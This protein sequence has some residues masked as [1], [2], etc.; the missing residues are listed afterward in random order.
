M[1]FL[2]ILVAMTET[3]SSRGLQLTND[4]PVMRDPETSA[5]APRWPFAV[6]LEGVCASYAH[7]PHPALDGVRLRLDPG[8]RV[9]LVGPSGAGKTTVVNLLLRFLDP[10]AGRVTVA[11]RDAREYRQQDVRRTIAVAG[12]EAHLFTASIR[13]NVRLARPDASDPD[14][15]GA[16]ARADLGLGGRASQRGRHRGRGAGALAVRRPAPADC[17]GLGVPHGGAGTGARRADR[18]S[19]SAHH[20]RADC[21]SLLGGPRQSVLLITHRTEELELVDR[22]ISPGTPGTPSS[23]RHVSAR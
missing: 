13:D 10:E 5:P 7:Q 2:W 3:R 16:A 17:P 14:R 23:I 6:A 9:A 20:Q 21:R 12:Q 22:V 1:T 15:A 18:L 19:G 8:E 4:E 11:E